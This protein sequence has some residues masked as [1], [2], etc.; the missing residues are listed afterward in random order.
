MKLPLAKGATWESSS[1]CSVSGFGPTPIVIKRTT[2]NN[3]T[4]SRRVR[5]AGEEVNVWVIT[6]SETFE[7][8]GRVNEATT[9]TWFS[10]AH[11]LIVRS[12]SK[13]AEGDRTLEVLNL[14]PE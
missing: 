11:G 10:G 5:V 6:A 7:A 3:V 13:T 1:T 12:E 8:A 4:E 9:T 14:K 2:K